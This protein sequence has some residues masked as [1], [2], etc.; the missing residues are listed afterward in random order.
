M[1]ID[2]GY[3]RLA[4]ELYDALIGAN[5]TKIQARV[6]HAVCR[7][8]YGFNKKMDRIADSQLAELT[9]LPRQKVNKAKN[10]LVAMNVLIKS[11]HQIGINKNLSQWSIPDC[12]QKN[13]IVTETGTTGADPICHQ[14]ADSVTEIETRSERQEKGNVVT[15]TGAENVTKTVI[16]L[17]P[18]PGHTKDTITKDKKDIITPLSP[19]GDERVKTVFAFWQKNLAHPKARLDTKRAKRIRA[20]LKEKFSAEDL[21]QAITGAT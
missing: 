16:A 6:A 2:G 21:C 9:R 1:N 13:N 11:H 14:N 10:E 7:K 20:R 19:F 4:N 12:Q 17:S 18:K 3:T 5:L 8:T 15:K